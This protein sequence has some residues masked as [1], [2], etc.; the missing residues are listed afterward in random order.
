MGYLRFWGIHRRGT[1][2]VLSGDGSVLREGGAEEAFLFFCF[3]DS[4]FRKKICAKDNTFIFK[5][6]LNDGAY[7]TII[8]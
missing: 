5:M 1:F 2:S 7:H 8:L 6:I 3:N 4:L